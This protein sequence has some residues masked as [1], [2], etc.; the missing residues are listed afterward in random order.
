MNQPAQ[1]R[2]PT[3]SVLRAAGV[4]LGVLGAF[5][6]AAGWFTLV[7][8][9]P[10]VSAVVVSTPSDDHSSGDGGNVGLGSGPAHTRTWAQ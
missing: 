4:G 5:G 8:S 1:N 7:A 10:A 3:S 9:D 2:K 6:G